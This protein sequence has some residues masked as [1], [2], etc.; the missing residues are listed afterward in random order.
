MKI[1]IDAQVMQSH[2][3]GVAKITREMYA[4]SDIFK[5]VELVAVCRGELLGD[6]DKN[7]KVRRFSKLIPDFFWKNVVFP[8]YLNLQKPSIVH[9]PWNGG[10]PPFIRKSHK[11]VTTICDVLPLE[12][13]N[14]FPNLGA[15]NAY[16][17]EIQSSIDKSDVIFTISKYSKKQILSN[18]QVSTPILL[19]T[20]GSTLTVVK[21][22]ESLDKENYLY[23][24]GY[25]G[26]KGLVSLLQTFLNLKERGM[27]SGKLILVGK[28]HYFSDEFKRLVVKGSKDG[29]VVETG[30]IGDKQLSLL[31]QDSRALIYPSKYEG[32]GL[33]PLEAMLHGCPVLTTPFSSIPEVCGDAALYV[34]PENSDDFSG[35]ILK[36]EHDEAMRYMMSDRGCLQA[37]KFSWEKAAHEF[38]EAVL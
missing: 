15:L 19:T 33:P 26:R 21:T 34:D 9:F 30:Y 8:L 5:D 4:Q 14:Y 38:L 16:R 11:I 36:L 24:G 2:F 25:D 29:S 27:V 18:F 3:T 6:L 32:F 28:T 35:A 7:I 13:P 31:Y 37:R 1:F 22:R 10:V 12:I 20:L 17:S 23:V